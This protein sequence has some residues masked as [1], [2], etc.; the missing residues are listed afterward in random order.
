MIRPQFENVS[1]NDGLL[2]FTLSGVNVSLANALRRTLISDI[3]TVV[4][5]T[6]PYEECKAVIYKNTT[7]LNNEILKQRLSC[8]PIHITDPDIP[9]ANYLLEVNVENLTDSVQYVTT[10]DFKVKNL[11]TN[12]FLK[13]ED[14]DKIFPPNDF[15]G[16]YIDFVRLRPKISNTILGEKLH[17]TCEFS[18]GNA[19]QDAMFNT[20]ATCSYG[21]SVDETAASSEL[22]KQNQKW[23]DRDLSK[24][25]IDFE[26][27]NWKLLEKMRIVKKDSF[28]FILQSVG[29]FSNHDLIKK[30]STI[31]INK[32]NSLETLI[33][34]E[35]LQ[36]VVSENTMKNCFDVILPNEDYTI[37]KILEYM[38][39]TKYFENAKTLSFCGF[40]KTHPHDPDSIIRIAFKEPIEK[41]ILYDCLKHCIKE[42]VDAFQI[43]HDKF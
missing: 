13:K 11:T 26:N 17:L 28:D 21:M 42:L 41:P 10:A 7:R 32:L 2:S 1:E 5:K 37:G 43:I 31:I 8:I 6:T 22:E 25:E 40:I 30:A 39:Y 14:N 24:D 18:Y 38:L 35:E 33:G 27:K 34:V 29:V 3:Q 15:T 19:K 4:F 23:K 12:E 9:L 36:V 16:Y 20:T